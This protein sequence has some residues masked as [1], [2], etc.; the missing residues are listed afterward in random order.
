MITLSARW[1]FGGLVLVGH[2]DVAE[3]GAADGQL[4]LLGRERVPG[5]EVVDVLLDDHVAAAGK[6]G[7]L[8]ADQHGFARGRAL[9]VLGAVDEPEHVPFV[10][11]PEPVDLVDDL[12]VAAQPVH[13]TLGQLEAQVEP[14]GADVK[15]QIARRGD[16]GVTRPGE[17]AERMQAGRSRERRSAGPTTPPRSRPPTSAPPPVSGI[18]PSA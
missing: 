2:L 7:I 10:E 1:E 5:R 17:L 14:V 6:R 13:Q 18:P 4:L 16:R 3:L 15:Q 9:R 11:R 12:G 8:V